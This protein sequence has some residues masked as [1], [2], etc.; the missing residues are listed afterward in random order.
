LPAGSKLPQYRFAQ[1]IS[2]VFEPYLKTYSESEERKIIT[3]LEGIVPAQDKQEVIEYAVYQSSLKM[4]KSIKDSMRRCT[5]FSTSKALFDLHT[6]FKNVFKQYRFLMKQRIPAG[7][8]DISYE[9]LKFGLPGSNETLKQLPEKPMAE[10][11]EM[12]CV[13]IINTAEYCQEIVPQL[14]QNIEDKINPEYLD[15]IDLTNHASEIFRELIKQCINCLVSSLCA[16]C[17]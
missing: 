9:T 17:D 4:F 6:S 12:K 1:C 16:R 2:E 13:I 5:S 14:Q 15:K 8:Y 7:Q 3:M 10:E 11:V